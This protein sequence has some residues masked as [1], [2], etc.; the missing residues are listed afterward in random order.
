MSLT[1]LRMEK[2]HVLKLTS[3]SPERSNWMISSE[4]AFLQIRHRCVFGKYFRKQHMTCICSN[5][6]SIFLMSCLSL[7]FTFRF[8]R[9]WTNSVYYL[10]S[11]YYRAS[12]SWMKCCLEHWR[13]NRISVKKT[14]MHLISQRENNNNNNQGYKTT[15]TNSH[16]L[17]IANE[18]KELLWKTLALP[19]NLKCYCKARKTGIWPQPSPHWCFLNPIEVN[20]TKVAKPYNRTVAYDSI[21]HIYPISYPVAATTC[22]V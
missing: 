14:K 3:F 2:L 17:S 8:E 9:R 19:S 10:D 6:M 13:L 15:Y 4:L 5:K 18:E 7:R 1:H 22:K 21:M 12:P 16:S 11:C 20:G